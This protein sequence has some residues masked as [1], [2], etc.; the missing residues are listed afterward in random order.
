MIQAVLNKVN[1]VSS[2]Y[3]EKS[4]KEG[5]WLYVLS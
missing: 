3:R 2:V 4:E 5:F 1:K